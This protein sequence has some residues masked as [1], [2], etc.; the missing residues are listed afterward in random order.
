MNLRSR[1][2]GLRPAAAS[3]TRLLSGK[4]MR[5]EDPCVLRLTEPRSHRVV[6]FMVPMRAKIASG[7]SMNLPL[8]V[9]CPERGSGPR[10]VPGRSV[11]PAPA[12]LENHPR[13]RLCAAAAGGDRPRSESDWFMAPM[14]AKRASGLPMNRSAELQFGIV[15]RAPNGPIWKSALPGRCSSFQ[16]MQK[17]AAG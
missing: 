9:S 13:P 12:P 8:P 5:L 2:A 1:S 11:W 7:L 14:R 15:R 3:P 4:S 6:R 16:C 17:M 10:P